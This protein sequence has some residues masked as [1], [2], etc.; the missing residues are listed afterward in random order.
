VVYTSDRLQ[1]EKETAE[2]SAKQDEA[3]R[4]INAKKAGVA[5]DL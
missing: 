5:D 4:E 1:A 3:T 2:R